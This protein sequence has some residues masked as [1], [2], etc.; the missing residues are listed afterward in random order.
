MKTYSILFL[1]DVV[2]ALMPVEYISPRH[3][4]FNDALHVIYGEMG[5]GKLCDRT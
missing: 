2:Y 3:P 4:A 1:C 5:E